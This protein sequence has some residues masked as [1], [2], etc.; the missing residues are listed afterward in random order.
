MPDTALRLAFN[1][2]ALDLT[3]N[4]ERRSI[5]RSVTLTIEPGERVGI[6]GP[7]GAGKTQL[8][9]L[10]LRAYR[11][12]NGEISVGTHPLHTI[13]PHA[14]LRHV[15]YVP[16]DAIIFDGTV[17][18]NVRFA[19][20]THPH[21]SASEALIWQALQKAGLDLRGQLPHGLDTLVGT[22]GLRLS[23]GQRQRLSIAQAIYKLS[24]REQEQA[25]QLVIADEATSALD[26]ISEAHV[27][28]SLYQA[29]PRQTTMVMIAHRLS[30]L[31]GC[32]SILMVRPLEQC[33]LEQPQVT[34][35]TS[36]AELYAHEPLF[37]EMA[38]AQG[39]HP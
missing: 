2:V 16:Q 12:T 4:T 13:A 27:L 18:E 8:V 35:H 19:E 11:P 29:L 20:A 17:R 39:F 24:R 36:L 6:V 14:W 3:S 7:S 5:L 15:G 21:D 37:R 30:S 22:K 28:D 31:Y 32:D 34:K 25:P 10:L 33:P 38:K 9:N 26:S 1:D 23:G